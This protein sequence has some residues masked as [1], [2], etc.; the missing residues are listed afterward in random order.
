[1]PKTLKLL[2]AQINPTVG[3]IDANAEK[4]IDLIKKH[5]STHDAI[6]FPELAL[7][8][9][10][11][12]D[13]LFRSEFF[14]QVDEALKRIQAH[15]QNCHVILG[16]P[17]HEKSMIY[18][19][20]S[21][22]FEEQRIT[23]YHKQHLP[24]DGVFDEM[25]YFTKG[26]NDLCLFTIKGF[27]IGLCI[28]EDLWHPGPV[29][30]IIDAHADLLFCINASPFDEHKPSRRE[31]LL[32]RYAKRGIAIIY[33]NQVGGQDELV[34]DGQSLAFDAQG[35]LCVRSKA[36]E[37]DLTTVTVHDRKLMGEIS[38]PM[39]REAMIYR[40]LVCGLKSYI[41]K[42]HFYI[43]DR[44]KLLNYFNQS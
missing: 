34:F 25:R 12:E 24:N 9:Y 6:I 43:L 38:L 11:P 39:P 7:T 36:F 14:H 41:E 33:V 10:P 20:A 4:I 44:E 32:H 42:N 18:N 1:M 16:H 27:L 3:A 26:D 8:G 5:Q 15:S 40:A 19:S 37:E 22:F 17:S 23:L 13:L 30:Q 2:M 28:C 31:A 29:D 35:T 21:V